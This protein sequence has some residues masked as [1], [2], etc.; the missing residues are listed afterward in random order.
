MR[1]A[2]PGRGKKEER[3]VSSFKALL[4]ALKIA[5]PRAIEAQ[6]I[7]ALAKVMRAKGSYVPGRDLSQGTSYRL[8]T[9]FESADR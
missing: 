1:S 8:G 4:E 3:S 2:G 5:K 6:R 9:R 7:G